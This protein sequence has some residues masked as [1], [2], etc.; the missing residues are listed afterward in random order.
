LKKSLY[1]YKY[2]KLQDVFNYYAK[3]NYEIVF[4]GHSQGGALSGFLALY[5]QTNHPSTKISLITFGAPEYLT[6]S[7]I[8]S[9]SKTITNYCRVEINKDVVPKASK[10]YNAPGYGITYINKYYN[11]ILGIHT[12]YKSN[13]ANLCQNVCSKFHYSYYVK[14][15]A[16][17]CP[18][19]C[20]DQNKIET[21]PPSTSSKVV[22]SKKRKSNKTEENT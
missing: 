17:A 4:T 2:N 22:V 21:N 18:E 5:F 9:F 7:A 6:S 10:F 16:Q 3:K 1:L 19:K 15:L 11:T 12:S 20:A 8:K 13:Y 14:N